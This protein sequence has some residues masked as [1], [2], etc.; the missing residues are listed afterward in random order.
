VSHCVCILLPK[1]NRNTV[2][3]REIFSFCTDVKIKNS[4][5]TKR[6]HVL[7]LHI[8]T[9]NWWQ[10]R[11]KL[12]LST[13]SQRHFRSVYSSLCLATSCPRWMR[14]YVRFDDWLVFTGKISRSIS[15]WIV[16][17]MTWREQ[18]HTLMYVILA[19]LSL[20]R[21]WPVTGGEG[22]AYSRRLRRMVGG[23]SPEQNGQTEA[24]PEHNVSTRRHKRILNVLL[25]SLYSH[26]SIFLH[27]SIRRRFPT[28][29][30]DRRSVHFP[31]FIFARNE[32][33]T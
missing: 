4:V 18:S 15:L 10:L 23:H 3:D 8:C 9:Y 28:W 22:G 21:R 33:N 13:L 11:K 25:H 16:K 31:A 32:E 19:A 1:G 26:S 29:N 7:I 6:G 30:W 14:G 12:R 20:G 17:Q 2:S 24:S 5:S 27:W